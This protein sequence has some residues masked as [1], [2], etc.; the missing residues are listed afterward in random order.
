PG[1]PIYLDPTAQETPI[2]ALGGAAREALRM[3]DV[4]ETMLQGVKDTFD[5]QNRRQIGETKR[6]DDVLDRLNT[7]IKAYVTALDT[8][9]M[10]SDDLRRAR[11]ILTFATNIEQAGD[12]VDRNLLG[13]ANKLAKRGV[14]FS[15]EGKAELLDMIDR[16]IA[17]VRAASSLFLTGDD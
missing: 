11:E 17:N 7:A 5:R 1:R 3:A 10:G 15:E 16:L 2:I 12:T 9:A 6:M 8:D 14:S 4:L 13:I